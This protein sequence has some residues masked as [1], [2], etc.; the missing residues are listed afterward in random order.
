LKQIS[1]DLQIPKI[2]RDDFFGKLK[3]NR[4]LNWLEGTRRRGFS[5]YRI[6]IERDG[7][8][9][10]AKMAW[11]K[12]VSIEERMTEIKSVIVGELFDTYDTSWE[13]LGK[14]TP[15]RFLKKIRLSSI[16][17]DADGSCS[18]WFEDGGLFLGHEIEVPISKDGRIATAKLQG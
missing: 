2:F 4:R 17:I 18:A 12:V 8:T 7:E 9:Y 14:L 5:K 16:H 1:K 13:S 6:S 10:D 11:D 15:E 3:L